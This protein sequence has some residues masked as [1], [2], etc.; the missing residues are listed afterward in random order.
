MP[1]K[2]AMA[3]PAM[4]EEAPVL[5]L[6]E[7]VQDDGTVVSLNRQPTRRP[8]PEPDPEPMPLTMPM[9]DPAPMPQAQIAMPEQRTDWPPMG[10]GMP[11]G[12]VSRDTEAAATQAFA[13]L[14]GTVSAVTGVP[15]GHPQRT[16]EELARELLRPM[17]KQWLDRNLQA[18]VA[19]AVEREISRLSG[20]A[21][22]N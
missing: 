10:M 8:M 21:D 2:P 7:V 18:I 9:L 11:E 13:G 5:D 16:I 15:L 17:L 3:A 22:K 12:L 1:E 14:A 19:R 4:H 6:T 20:R